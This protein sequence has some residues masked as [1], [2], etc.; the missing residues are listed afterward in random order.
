MRLGTSS[1]AHIFERVRRCAEG[2]QPFRTSSRGSERD[3]LTRAEASVLHDSLEGAVHKE[4]A[5][6]HRVSNNTLKTQVGRLLKKT[7]DSSLQ[8]AKS[9]RPSV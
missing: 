7:C 1:L 6:L 8:V 3:R 2:S 4:I 9:V 5:R